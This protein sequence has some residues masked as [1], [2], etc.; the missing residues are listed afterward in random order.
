MIND[1]GRTPTGAIVFVSKVDEKFGGHSQHK[2]ELSILHP[3]FTFSGRPWLARM[4]MK[5]DNNGQEEEENKNMK[6]IQGTSRHSSRPDSDRRNRDPMMT[7]MTIGP[8][9]PIQPIWRPTPRRRRNNRKKK[10][11]RW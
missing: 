1:T 6:D 9:G 11:T 7:M 4:F 10:P 8:G 2:D 3:F 5:D